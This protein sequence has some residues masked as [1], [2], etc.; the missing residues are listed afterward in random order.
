MTPKKRTKEPTIRDRLEPLSLYPLD[1]EEALARFMDA[2]PKK[3]E[4][5]L[6]KQGV[7]R[8]KKK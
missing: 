4:D 7:K 1:A 2:D 5:R 3:V 8:D 6:K